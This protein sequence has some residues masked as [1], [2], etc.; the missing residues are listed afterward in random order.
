MN[1]VPLFRGTEEAVAYGHALRDEIKGSDYR[2]NGFEILVFAWLVCQ[3]A[4]NNAI[5]ANAKVMLATR[6]QLLRESVEAFYESP[7]PISVSRHGAQGDPATGFVHRAVET[8]AAENSIDL[9]DQPTA[10]D[11]PLEVGAS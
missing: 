10:G 6:C 8:A 9:R 2:Q 5:S 3:K 11:F 1:S 4:V 7:Q